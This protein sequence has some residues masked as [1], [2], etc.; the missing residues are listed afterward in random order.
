LVDCNLSPWSANATGFSLASAS[1]VCLSIPC[2]DPATKFT[3]RQEVNDAI[4][5]NP[6]FS[7]RGEP[8]FD[9]FQLPGVMGVGA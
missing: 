7:G 2:H 5:G 6:R 1:A 4:G 8:E 9:K 3:E